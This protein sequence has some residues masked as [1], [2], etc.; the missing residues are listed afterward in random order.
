MRRTNYGITTRNANG[1]TIKKY[2]D[3]ENYQVQHSPTYTHKQPNC[4]SSSIDIFLSNLP[5][6]H[7]IATVN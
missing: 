5:Y 1:V 7:K 2:A 3:S 4:R 6:S